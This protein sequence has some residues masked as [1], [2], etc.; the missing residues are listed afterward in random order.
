[1]KRRVIIRV[2]G[3]VQGVGFRS[4]TVRRAR[5]LNL[6]GFVRNE[7]DGSVLIVAEGEEE[8]L[9]RLIEECRQGPPSA[10]VEDV[11]I[12]WRDYKGEFEDFIIDY[13]YY[14]I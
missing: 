11:R 10:R 1:M 12:E 5:R 14:E 4:W 9:L 3:E 7:P 6:K 13:G 8:D 2:F